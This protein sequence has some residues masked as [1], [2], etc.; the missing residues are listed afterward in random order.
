VPAGTSFENA[1]V[2]VEGPIATAWLAIVPALTIVGFAVL[3]WLG[4]RRIRAEGAST[5]GIQ[6]GTVV[7]LAGASVLMVL[8]TSK[9]YSIQYIVWLLPFMALLRGRMFWLAAAIAA[10]TMPIHPLLYSELV[11]QEP[12]P[13]LL[14]NVR[15]GLLVALTVWFL[16]DLRLNAADRLIPRSES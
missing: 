3:G 16:A 8:V 6:A 11:N 9:V 5:G 14:L 1:R 12:L 13:V 2:Q 4:W 15:N 7:T 10:L